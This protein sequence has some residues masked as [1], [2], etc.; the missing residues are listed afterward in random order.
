MLRISIDS[1]PRSIYSVDRYSRPRRNVATLFEAVF[2]FRLLS[3]RLAE[4]DRIMWFDLEEGRQ[5]QVQL[6]GSHPNVFLV[7]AVAEG[8]V[9]ERAF[10][11]EQRWKGQAAPAPRPAPVVETFEAFDTRWDSK[12]RTL[13]QT[14]AGAISLFDKQLA[15]EVICRAGLEGTSPA[16]CDVEMRQSLFEEA[17]KL[18]P[19]LAAPAPCIYWKDSIAYQFSLFELQYLKEKQGLRIERFEEV[20]RAVQVYARKQQRQQRLDEIYKPLGQALQNL[21][22]RLVHRADTML[23]AL[24]Q[25]SRADQYERWGHLLIASVG[26]AEVGAEEVTLP[27]LFEQNQPVTIALD[28]RQTVV[29]NAERYYAKA[30]RTRQARVHAERR[31]EEIAT[32]VEEVG[33]LLERLELITSMKA[34]EA[35]KD[36]KIL[37]HYLRPDAIGESPVPFRRFVVDGGYEVWV[38]RSARENDILTL[39]HAQKHDLWFHARAVPGSHVILRLPGKNSQPN[40]RALEEAAAIAAHYSQAQHSGLVPVQYIERKYIVKPRGAAPGAV[41]LL[42]EKVLLVEPGLPR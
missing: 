24:S 18:I 2:D 35:F 27:D 8:S 6:F 15:A 5:F 3:V 32:D 14:V 7:K 29:E 26:Q 36:E 19:L 25:E 20:N 30:R 21:H 37:Q 17:R 28:P 9:V 10:R 33:R 31:L 41:R 40:R 34:L 1:G 23:E 38:G 4:R 22:Q 12:R 16:A 42:R 13:E 11:N 39:Q